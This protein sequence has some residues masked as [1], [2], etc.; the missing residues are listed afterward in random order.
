VRAPV[1]PM[2]R[3]E[4]TAEFFPLP[5]KAVAHCTIKLQA[6]CAPCPTTR[7]S[8]HSGLFLQARA[9]T[10]RRPAP[11][12]CFSPGSPCLHKHIP[13][14]HRHFYVQIETVQQTGQRSRAITNNFG[15]TALAN[16]DRWD[17]HCNHR[18]TGFIAPTTL[19]SGR[20][21]V[22]WRASLG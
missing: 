15:R 12:R 17:G 7:R 6:F 8:T 11:E 3:H 10:T 4:Q 18:G 16:S 19:K 2:R 5:R 9:A 21:I 22:T 13:T 1:Y 14:L 20:G